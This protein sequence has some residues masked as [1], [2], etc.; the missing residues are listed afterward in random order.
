M[1]LSILPAT[2]G[3]LTPGT[4]A[5]TATT[6][7]ARPIVSA[8]AN[9]VQGDLP[10]MYRERWRQSDDE[11]KQFPLSSQSRKVVEVA[12]AL[13]GASVMACLGAG[14]SSMQADRSIDLLYKAGMFNAD[15]LCTDDFMAWVDRAN[16]WPGLVLVPIVAIV[17]ARP[18]AR[19][20]TI[21]DSLESV[22]ADAEACIV[23]E[24]VCGRVSFDSA[25]GGMVCV[26]D[27]S[28]GRLRWKCA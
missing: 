7:R 13:L 3:F 20:A 16:Q 12:S 26:E 10:S 8:N 6:A 15:V 11:G 21:T 27:W 23:D 28:Q 19:A 1:L 9:F 2:L 24:Q 5:A 14:A 22:F 4:I 18:T 17:L 25:E